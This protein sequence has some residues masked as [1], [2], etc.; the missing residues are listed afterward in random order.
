MHYRQLANHGRAR[1][2]EFTIRNAPSSRVI[3]QGLIRFCGHW[4]LGF[5][6]SINFQRVGIAAS[7]QLRNHPFKESPF[8]LVAETG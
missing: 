4:A 8:S 7:L 6:T 3:C 2:H 1:V 5:P